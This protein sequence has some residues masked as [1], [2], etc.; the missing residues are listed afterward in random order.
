MRADG[1][2]VQSQ[3]EWE[4][5]RDYLRAMLQH[6]LYGS[7]PVSADDCRC[8]E[9]RSEVVLGGLARCLWFT[10]HFER[11]GHCASL[12]CNVLIPQGSG[13]FPVIIKNTF[14]L[15]Y[16]DADPIPDT[17]QG[18][19]RIRIEDDEAVVHDAVKRGYALCKFIRT[20][21]A[22]DEMIARNHGI[23]PLYPE[24]DWGAIAVWAWAYQP[25][26]DALLEMPAIDGEKIVATG[27]SRGGK[28]ALCAAVYDE[29]IQLAVP[30]SSGTGGTGSL[31]YFDK[32]AGQPQTIA[33][34][35][36]QRDYWWGPRF[37]QFAQHVDKLPFDAHILKVLIAPRLLMNPHALQ[38]YHANPYGTELC[39]RAAKLVFQWLGCEE[40][41]GIHWRQG[42][43][44]QNVTDWS[45]LLDFADKHFLG[46]DSGRAFQ[47]YAYPEAEP[48]C[49]WTLPEEATGSDN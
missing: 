1:T 41:I 18:T 21:L 46:K 37:L 6:Y 24:C 29:R 9:T 5:Q 11:N 14:N 32:A 27:H 3:D 34:H 30:N 4:Q 20:D 47:S 13:P 44:A 39:H 43:H 12:R 17:F 2:R 45:A 19:E 22:A 8:E 49:L 25:I 23:Y 26:I 38:D 35:Q 48:E 33:S 10:L 7:M 42:G 28:T 15:Y 36:G 31:K 16:T 40:H